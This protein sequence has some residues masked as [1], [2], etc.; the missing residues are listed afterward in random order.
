MIKPKI[1]IAEDDKFLSMAYKFQLEKAGYEILSALDGDEALD[2]VRKDKPALIL[3]DIVMPKKSGFTV[4]KELKSDPELSKI[5][6]IVLTNLVHD[7]DK[8]TALSLGAVNYVN[9]AG[10]SLADII[11]TLEKFVGKGVDSVVPSTCAKCNLPLPVGVKFCSG[12]G[13]KR[14]V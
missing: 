14:A 11:S 13:T 1:L 10:I 7:E 4:L 3:L 2:M 6:V 5:P 8:Q 12:C 9:K